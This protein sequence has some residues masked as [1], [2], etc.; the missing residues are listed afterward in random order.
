MKR[1]PVPGWPIALV[2]AALSAGCSTRGA[3]ALPPGAP[4]WAR[5]P[6]ADGGNLNLLVVTP[7]GPP[8]G[9]VVAFPWGAGDAGLLAGMIETYWSEAAPA[10]GY[11]VIGV[12]IRGSS[13]AGGAR[14]VM[15][16]VLG[17]AD[18]NLPGATGPLVLTGASAGGVGVFHA[19]AAAPRRVDAV[20]AM[21]GRVAPEVPLD[22]LSG[23]PVRLMVGERD[24][25][26][27]RISEDAMSRLEAAGA[28]VTLDV[29][30]GQGHVLRVPQ[31]ELVA[32]IEGL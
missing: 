8:R 12:E 19:A 22:R 17:W 24:G 26:W 31:G 30:A 20:L 13:L 28:A 5:A 23:V 11:A 9:L 14:G 15:E 32:W 7:A 10:A 29:V 27:I 6:L 18:R 3:G 1:P 25:R 16:A 4:Q 2:L 21:P